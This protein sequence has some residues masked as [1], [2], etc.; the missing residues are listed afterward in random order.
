[1]GISEYD[2]KKIVIRKVEGTIPTIEGI[3][4]KISR[5]MKAAGKYI[6]IFI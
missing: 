2:L 4:R 3:E 6:H 5:D 1:M